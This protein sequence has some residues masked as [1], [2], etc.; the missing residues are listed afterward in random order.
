MLN[1]TNDQT[2]TVQ[3]GSINDLWILLKCC[4]SYS[5]VK[6]LSQIKS[7]L[8]YPPD[9]EQIIDIAIITGLSYIYS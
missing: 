9:R 3:L 2:I 7:C 6:I 1:I 8:S 4:S 5:A